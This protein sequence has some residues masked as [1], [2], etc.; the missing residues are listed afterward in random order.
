M[1][2]Y[3][4]KISEK[5]TVCILNRKQDGTAPVKPGQRATDGEKME[6]G[7]PQG[8]TERD[9]GR[10]DWRGVQCNRGKGKI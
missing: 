9:A 4:K 8:E 2:H 10:L 5:K 7:K 1:I 6:M 3:K